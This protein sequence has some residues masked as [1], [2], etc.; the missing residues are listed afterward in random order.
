[1]LLTQK[2]PHGGDIYH[3]DT[4][5]DF[6]SNVNPAGIHPH[7]RET[8]I[9]ATDNADKY[10]DPYCTQLR[11]KLEEK[12]GVNREKIL[13]GNGAAD[14][15]YSFAMALPGEK[16]SLIPVPTFC[17]YE[18]AMKAAGKPFVNEVNGDLKDY[19]AIFL[20]TP[21]NPTGQLIP[22]EGIEKIAKTG[23]RI[24]LDLTFV[25]LTDNPFI[26]NLPGLLEFYPNIVALKAFTKDHALAGVR[27]GYCMS[28]DKEFLNRM[29]E[30]SQC[31]NVSTI[32]QAA[33]IAA[34]E[35]DDEVKTQIRELCAERDRVYTEL[36]KIPNLQVSPS[37]TNFLL[38]YSDRNLYYKLKDRKIL[39]RDCSEEKG[40]GKGYIRIT[41]KTKLENEMLINVLREILS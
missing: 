22:P 9:K 24:L 26:Y 23:I 20:C 19:E 2:N 3:N 12:E 33:G 30:K 31:W 34:L 28:S 18:T 8:I 36:K 10:P 13:C 27:L 17:E 41:I 1:M 5:F 14:L 32:A 11:K 38:L 35:C 6:S 40:L 21:N 37:S 16:P 15:I 39:V 4:L 29:A 7:V 25:T